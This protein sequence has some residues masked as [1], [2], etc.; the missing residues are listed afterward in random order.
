VF[1]AMANQVHS[2]AGLH[3]D[4]RDPRPDASTM[5]RQKDLRVARKDAA[6][7]ARR[8]TAGAQFAPTG[9]LRNRIS[10]KD[11]RGERSRRSQ[12]MAARRAR[13]AYY[14]ASIFNR[15]SR[16]S[17]GW[18][19]VQSREADDLRDLRLRSLASLSWR[20]RTLPSGFDQLASLFS[21]QDPT[22]A[23]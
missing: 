7:G 13:N 1:A 15:K 18:H 12:P 19:Q 9:C 16:K 3:G 14:K 11:V 17:R 8:F 23:V 6:L 10:R 4:P 20:Q 22:A 5:C 21:L 2:A